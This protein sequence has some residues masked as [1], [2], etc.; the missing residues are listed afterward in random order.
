MLISQLHLRSSQICGNPWFKL[1]KRYGRPECCKLEHFSSR[2]SHHDFQRTI[3]FSLSTDFCVLLPLV[4]FKEEITI[5]VV[6]HYSKQWHSYRQNEQVALFQHLTIL[7]LN[8]TSPGFGL[9]SHPSSF[10]SA[11]WWPSQLFGEWLPNHPP[12]Q[13]PF[14]AS[15][16]DPP[17]L[18]AVRV[19]KE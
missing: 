1:R 6:F 7:L 15:Q 16:Q 19:E 12:S 5:S 2:Q 8:P 4:H 9:S 13:N 3:V 14:G 10:I 11:L 18:A 17:L